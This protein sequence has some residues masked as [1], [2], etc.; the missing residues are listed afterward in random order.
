MNLGTC[1]K[2]LGLSSDADPAQAKR[3]YKT[4][5]RRWHPD[6]FPEGSPSKAGAEEQLK[7]INVAYARVKKH[8]TAVQPTPE[9][10]PESTAYRP[11][12]APGDR[13]ADPE[14]GHRSWLDAVF[15]TMY[16]FIRDGRTTPSTTPPNTPSANRSKRFEQVLEEMAGGSIVPPKK[17]RRARADAFR[18]HA[19][20]YGRRGHGG[21]TVDAVEGAKRPGPVR[22]VGRV[23]G[24]G[25]RR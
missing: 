24:I 12:A 3:A 14:S 22:P 13:P 2:I 17:S 1:F 23:R 9:S 16:A 5:V 18:R 6:Q 15:N 11:D 7:Q 4:Q 8:L 20:G 25:K 21:S 19:T 10:H